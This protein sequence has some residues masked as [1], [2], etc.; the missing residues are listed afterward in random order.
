MVFRY[1]LFL[2]VL[3]AAHYAASGQNLSSVPSNKQDS[4]YGI[5]DS[6]KVAFLDTLRGERL[7]NIDS[8]RLQANQVIGH[9]VDNLNNASDSVK[10]FL[11]LLNLDSN[12]PSL[13][14]DNPIPQLPT[15][16]VSSVENFSLLKDLNIPSA[17]YRL[18][19]SPT[20]KEVTDKANAIA[21]EAIKKEEHIA[22]VNSLKNATPEFPKADDLSLDAEALNINADEI[23]SESVDHF[24][25]KTSK[26]SSAKNK[27]KDIKNKYSKVNSIAELKTKSRNRIKGKPVNQ[28]LIPGITLQFFKEK[29][30]SIDVNPNLGYRLRHNLDFGLGYVYRFDALEF[31]PAKTTYGPRLYLRRTLKKSLS[32]YTEFESL[33]TFIP[34]LDHQVSDENESRKWVYGVNIG[35]TK[36]FKLYKKLQ[37]STTVLIDMLSAIGVK[38][39]SAYNNNINTRISL[40][41]AHK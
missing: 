41:I 1:Y 23:K 11:D 36:K 18:P 27:L 20:K 34:P 33:R 13:N 17:D 29:T 19:K 24:K 10:R 8:G 2:F 35:L 15:V 6:I 31:E 14:L 40:S 28:R 16:D 21:V 25:G 5:I 9:Q 26:L 39:A 3:I 4:V 30:F 12:L 32:L 38:Q 7:E 22:E 37:C